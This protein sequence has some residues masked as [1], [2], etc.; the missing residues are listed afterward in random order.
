M[1]FAKFVTMG[2][3]ELGW[4]KRVRTRSCGDF[5]YSNS[6]SQRRQSAPSL[7]LSKALTKPKPV[8]RDCVPQIS[9][10][11]HN[12]IQSLLS[13]SRKLISQGNVLLQTGV[14]TQER[15]LLLFTDLLIITKAKS[16]VQVK[17]KACVRVSEMWTASCVEE[18][19]EAHTITERSFVMGWPTYNCVATFSTS[20]EKER[21]LSVIESCIKE[22]KQYDDP[23]IIPLEIFSKD[24]ENCDHVKTISV[25]NTDCTSDVISTALK[26]FGLSGVIKDY[27]LWVSSK[28]DET[29][30]PLIGHEFPYCIKMSHMRSLQ[31]DAVT[32]SHRQEALLPMDSYCQFFLRPRQISCTITGEQKGRKRRTSLI[33]W[34]L[35]RGFSI[36]QDVHSESPASSGHTMTSSGHLFGQPLSNVIKDNTL[37]SPVVD[38]LMCLCSHGAKTPGILR[39]SA[40]VKACRE[41]REKLDSGHHERLLNEESV[42]VT[43]AVF[44]DFLRNIPGSLLCEELYELWLR[45]IEQDGVKERRMMEIKQLQEVQ[46]LLQLLP[47]ENLLL[48]R[49]VIAMLHQIQLNAEHNQMNSYN[50]AVCIAPSCLWKSC[51]QSQEEDAKKVCDLVHFLIDNCYVLFGTDIITLLKDLTEDSRSNFGSVGSLQQMSDSGYDSLKNE[52]NTETEDILGTVPLK[53]RSMDSLISSDYDLDCPDDGLETDSTHPMVQSRNVQHQAH[54]LQRDSVTGHAFKSHEHEEHLTRGK[55]EKVEIPAGELN[56]NVLEWF[57]QLKLASEKDGQQTSPS[58]FLHNTSD[59]LK[60]SLKIFHSPQKFSPKSYWLRRKSADNQ[61]PITDGTH[62][63]GDLHNKTSLSKTS[64]FPKSPPSYQVDLTSLNREVP[65]IL[66]QVRSTGQP[67]KEINL[68]YKGPGNSPSEDHQ[69]F[70]T[71]QN[72]KHTCIHNSETGAGHDSTCIK[73]MAKEKATLPESMFFGQSR[74]LTVHREENPPIINADCKADSLSWK[75]RTFKGSDAFNLKSE[76]VTEIQAV[77]RSHRLRRCSSSQ[78]VGEVAFHSEESYV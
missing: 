12:L 44:K 28:K 50:L 38:M 41:L 59:Y 48:L 17:K 5:N 40:G 34:A 8:Y 46:R 20:E 75:K 62:F 54:E 76:K 21:W 11:P 64:L 52:V 53:G 33:S 19:C 30:Y 68:L 22:E 24:I 73:F 7:T 3:L 66:T 37:P 63:E 36:E 71:P 29:P 4:Q 18:V 78:W 31:P 13:P 10:D 43:A 45:A 26:Q 77:G 16:V 23:Q 67:C 6:I 60:S 74:K 1:F 35:K 27:Q 14:Q 57:Q 2:S 70:H 32:S 69:M 72:F 15:Y 65:Q 47:M 55:C 49:H 25:S 61:Y 51:L 58:L 42:F 56:E 39:R 9:Q